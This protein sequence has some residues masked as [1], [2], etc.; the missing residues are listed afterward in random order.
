MS[1][2]DQS[3]GFTVPSSFARQD[4][5]SDGWAGPAPPP[6]AP[7]S[8]E[9]SPSIA[10]SFAR[11]L[12][13][14]LVSEHGLPDD[15]RR[16]GA[17]PGPGLG[18]GAGAQNGGFGDNLLDDG[19]RD[20]PWQLPRQDRV[21]LVLQGDLEGWMVKHH[22]WLVLQPEKGTSVS[23][24]YSDF[25]WLIEC[26]TRRYPFRLLPALPPKRLQVS[27][28]YLAT[29]ELFLER[30]RRGLE[31]ALTSL[32]N[33]PVIKHDA[34]LATFMNDQS[35]LASYR[36]TAHLSL[37][38]E[39]ST[40]TLT[41]L[42]EGSLPADI[43]ARLSSLRQRLPLLVDSW[44]KIT[45]ASERVSHRRLNQG[46]EWDA[47]GDALARALDAEQQ[48]WRPKQVEQTEREVRAFRGV[49]GDVAETEGASAR[50]NLETVV[51]DLKR[52]R[53]LYTTLRELFARQTTLGV[54]NVDKLK[55]RTET[56]LNKLSLLRSVSPRPATFDADADKLASAI[57]ADQRA[58]DAA[59]RR[60]AFV[61]WCVW[62]EVQ[63]AF[64]STSLLQLSLRDFAASETGYSKRLAEQWVALAEAL[65]PSEG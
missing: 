1:S 16:A 43:D 28:H 56:N 36:K 62:Q 4:S 40:R 55:K 57:E 8:D 11:P 44:T 54:D 52:H 50:R 18:G 6:A 35:D 14:S 10:H 26:L 51:E 58:I 12:D 33:H 13:Y 22:V 9:P 47:L 2:F 23:R 15:P 46:K 60:R 41:P 25:V 21:Q 32:V 34:L 65:G 49:V 64:R 48:G 3:R 27:G 45:V 19:D 30:R 20:G 29:D 53:E 42:E 5:W 59:L 38:E 61:R 39:S 37:D 63:W 7:L 17:G 31:R 24:R